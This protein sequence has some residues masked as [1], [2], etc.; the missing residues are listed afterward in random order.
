MA[1]YTKFEDADFIAILNQFDIGNFVAAKGIAEGVENTNY[2]LTTTKNKFIL[3]VYEERVNESDLPFFVELMQKL[4]LQNVP[5][6]E[7]IFAKNGGAILKHNGKILTIVSF[8][9]GKSPTLIKNNHVEQIGKYLAKIHNASTQVVLT[10]NNALSLDFWQSS[11]AKLD[12]KADANFA[13]ITAK[14]QNA[15]AKIQNNWPIDLPSGVIHADLFPD[16]VFFEEDKSGAESLSAILDFY[17]A[18]NDIFAYDI[19][20]TLNA[21][22]FESDYSFNITKA[23]R[24][25][26]AYNAER[27]LT[28][29]EKQA[30]PLLC[31]GAALRFLLTRLHAYL[32]QVEGALVKVK[33]PFEYLKK[34][35]FHAQVKSYTEYGL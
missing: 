27:N 4:S 31:A 14:I 30:L 17:M 26:N 16:N 33:N 23:S 25:L 20:I 13:G 35:E 24:L 21:W 18:C 28:E 3:T 7:P 9:N 11:I 29:A 12:E 22:C 32:N 8:L 2:L 10:R 1:V 15:F 34:M 5:C 6:P 19:A